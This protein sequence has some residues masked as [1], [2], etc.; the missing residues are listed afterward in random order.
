MK[1]AQP[2][3]LVTLKLSAGEFNPEVI[4]EAIRLIKHPMIR[5][6]EYH[7][8]RR[9]YGDKWR[10][11][12]QP[13]TKHLRDKLQEPEMGNAGQFVSTAKL[14]VA[15]FGPAAMS[16]SQKIEN[17]YDAYDAAVK[18]IAIAEQCGLI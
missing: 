13:G 15:A 4:V 5:A 7:K 6:R 8:K 10:K 17:T 3:R 2:K 12:S 18:H 1:K 11:L 14:L 9:L 16:R